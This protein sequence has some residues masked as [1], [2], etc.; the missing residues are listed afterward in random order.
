MKEQFNLF[1]ESSQQFLNE[2]AVALPQIIGAL[3]I[4]LIGWIIA[5]VIKRLSVRGLRL[6]RFNYLTEKSGISLWPS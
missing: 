1:L 3:L 4:L 5:R 2:I 6:V